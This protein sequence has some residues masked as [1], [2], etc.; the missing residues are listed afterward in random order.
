MCAAFIVD[1]RIDHQ[2]PEILLVPLS[3]L[4][5]IHSK[6]HHLCS[7]MQSLLQK[8]PCFFLRECWVNI[9]RRGSA[10]TLSGIV[11]QNL[12]VLLRQR[13]QT[14]V[15][16]TAKLA[17]A[18]NESAL[19]VSGLL[20]LSAA[21]ERENHSCNSP[22]HQSANTSQSYFRQQ[23]RLVFRRQGLTG[24]RRKERGRECKGNR[25]P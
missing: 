9:S 1:P 11:W 20:N 5:L 25:L 7:E 24:Q 10:G 23:P 4:N 16:K 8:K 21:T 2:S 13:V 14:Q 6:Q 22:P 12:T 19:F 3:P 18:Q 17:E 15:Q